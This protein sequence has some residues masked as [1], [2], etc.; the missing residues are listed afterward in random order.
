M[1]IQNRRAVSHP[2]RLPWDREMEVLQL[3][4]AG[5]TN[6]Q[7][8]DRLFLSPHTVRAHL[9]HIYTKLDISTRA[10]AVRFTLEHDLV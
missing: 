7:I 8:A 10:E 2:N 3:A 1:T 6:G 4:A 9:H 5:L